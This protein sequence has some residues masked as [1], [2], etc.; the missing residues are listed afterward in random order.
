MKRPKKSKPVGV[1][2]KTFQILE[3]VR[4]S[5]G[6]LVLKDI[7]EQSGI[8][9]STAL[10]ILAHLE[11][12]AY[13]ARSPKGEYSI[14]NASPNAS[15]NASWQEALRRAARPLLWELWHN[16]Q[17]T[18]NLAVLEGP[19]VLY[20]DCLESSHDFRLVAN[21]GM[22]AVLYRTALGKAILAFS[23]AEKQESLLAPMTFRPF[24]PRTII[25]AEQFREELAMVKAQGWAIDNQESHLGLRCIAAPIL[26]TRC[27]AVGAVS[28]SGPIGRVT[29]EEVPLFIARIQ[30]AA[31]GISA[32]LAAAGVE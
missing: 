22:R 3:L 24:T 9:K 8:N 2:S 27:E 23:S 29:E 15:G 30:E 19:E 21:I 26:N 16:T 5:P 12:A 4:N 32:R 10:R 18:V 6:A 17:E 28:V 25:S 1:L 20:L 13:V 31:H 11:A 14:G 7:S